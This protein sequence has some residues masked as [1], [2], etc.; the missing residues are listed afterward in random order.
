MQQL[1][2]Y[3]RDLTI[4]LV[5]Q[6]AIFFSFSLLLLSLL[7]LKLYDFGRWNVVVIFCDE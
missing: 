6:A 3:Y 1:L 4:E 7:K 2:D 5:S